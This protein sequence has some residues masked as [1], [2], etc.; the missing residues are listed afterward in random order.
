MRRKILLLR[1]VGFFWIG[2]AFSFAVSGLQS[3]NLKNYLISLA[4]FAP[5][6]LAFA[7]ARSLG[8]KD[9]T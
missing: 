6:F 5:A 4:V 3:F 1:V 9:G 8:K 2:L 7:I